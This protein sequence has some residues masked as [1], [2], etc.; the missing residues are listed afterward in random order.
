MWWPGFRGEAPRRLAMNLPLSVAEH[1]VASLFAERGPARPWT[2]RILLAGVLGALAALPLVKLDVAVRTPGIVRSAAE[3]TELRSAAAGLVESVLA[4]E[5]DRVEAG[6]SLLVLASRDVAERLARNRALQAEHAGRAADFRRLAAL[7]AGMADPCSAPWNAP[8][9]HQEW[10]AHIAQLRALRLSEDKA[11]ADE[12]RIVAL[13]GRGIATQQEADNAHY[14]AARWRA[15]VQLAREQAQARWQAR[16]EDEDR[17]LAGLISEQQRIE[18]ERERLTLRAPATG[19]L[20]GFTGRNPGSF[21]GAGEVLGIVSPEDG[22]VVETAVTAHDIGYV[23]IDQSVRLQLDGYPGTAWR[24]FEGVVAR[25]GGDSLPADRSGAPVFQVLIRPLRTS[26][27]LPN[28][29]RAELRKGLTLSARFVV[30]RRS[31]LHLL[32]DEAGAWLNPQDRR[33]G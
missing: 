5:N 17:M 11:A 3:R 30:A 31:L 16:G 15:D 8:A 25:I 20:L 29:A 13:T 23:R 10:L 26:L 2:Y 27:S 1:T 7:A 28:G 32:Y 6:Q 33:T 22:L 4:G 9:L 19:V 18:E 24:T 14:E 12:S 21:V